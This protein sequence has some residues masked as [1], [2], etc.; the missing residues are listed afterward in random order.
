MVTYEH[1]RCPPLGQH[2]L[3]Q[4][5]LFSCF[6]LFSSFFFSI[7]V[8][9][10]LSLTLSLC[11]SLST[12]RR[13][14]AMAALQVIAMPWS[15]VRSSIEG[16]V[17]FAGWAEKPGMCVVLSCFITWSLYSLSLIFLHLH[18][19]LACLNNPNDVFVGYLNAALKRRFWRLDGSTLRYYKTDK[20]GSPK[21]V[22]PLSAFCMLQVPHLLLQV[23]E[24]DDRRSNKSLTVADSYC[25]LAS[26]MSK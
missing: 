1:E 25:A 24:N 18:T 8:S 9:A 2:H 26:D 15:P 17:E 12:N 6:A 22:I 7:L 20:A 23:L 14:Q 4:L 13:A 10:R 11:L 19:H 5:D 21:G 3:R 16:A